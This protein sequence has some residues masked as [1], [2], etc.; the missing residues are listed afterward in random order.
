MRWVLAAAVA[1][2]VLAGCG[3]GD[4]TKSTTTSAPP[5]T[6]TTTA[7]TP[8]VPTVTTTATVPT[9]ATTTT[10]TTP[11]PA[12]E[13]CSL[14]DPGFHAGGPLDCVRRGVDVHLVH[15][16]DIATLRSALVRLLAVNT[17]PEIAGKTKPF[18]P[19][20]F[21]LRTTLALTN[22]TKKPRAVRP[23]QTVLVVGNRQFEEVEPLE[24]GEDGRSLLSRAGPDHPIPPG[25]S[26]TG[27]VVYDV[28]SALAGQIPKG[29]WIAIAGWGPRKGVDGRPQV[30]GLALGV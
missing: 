9:T 5:P 1:A 17:S 22:L 24:N 18:I 7:R 12:A 29:A 6:T 28:P 27:E 30:A 8:T 25:G 16:R 13:G 15:K 19:K 20:G 4:S 11:E 3:I 10:A 23:F 2:G 21:Y 26:V 14:T